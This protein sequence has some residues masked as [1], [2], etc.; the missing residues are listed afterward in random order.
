[1]IKPV[2]G[3]HEAPEMPFGR[4]YH[5]VEPEYSKRPTLATGFMPSEGECG[6]D[7]TPTIREERY[8]WL[9]SCL[10][11]LE[12]KEAR[13]EYYARLEESSGSQ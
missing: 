10:Q 5:E 9:D 3:Y 2:E 11:G 12:G 8:S 4:L 13:H 6:A 7:I 1:M